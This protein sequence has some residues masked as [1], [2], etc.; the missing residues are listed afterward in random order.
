MFP[1]PSTH[2]NVT[3]GKWVGSPSVLRSWSMSEDMQ[4]SSLL[5]WYVLPLARLHSP[6]HPRSV[7]LGVAAFRLV[8]STA[9]PSLFRCRSPHVHAPPPLA[10]PHHD[11]VQTP[12]YLSD[13]GSYADNPED[14]VGRAYRM[15]SGMQWGGR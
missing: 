6:T 10:A 4:L 1:P 3:A 9:K 11:D 14:S 13:A 2:P 8:L 15:G 7:L 5:P 12:L